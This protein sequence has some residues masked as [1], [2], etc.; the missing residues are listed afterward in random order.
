MTHSFQNRN[1]PDQSEMFPIIPSHMLRQ[2]APTASRSP[3]ASDPHLWSVWT[4]TILN[5][6][7]Y[8]RQ[9]PDVKMESPSVECGSSNSIGGGSESESEGDRAP[10]GCF[11]GTAIPKNC[12]SRALENFEMFAPIRKSTE[13]RHIRLRPNALGML[14]AEGDVAD[15]QW[16]KSLKLSDD[17]HSNNALLE[18]VNQKQLHVRIVKDLQPGEEILLWF[19]EE[20]LALMYIPFLTPANIRGES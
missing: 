11:A 15:H 16:I 4:D 20:L 3:F 2:P 17:T 9:R 1:D 10:T 8:V 19:S 7:S 5:G 14:H 18:T 13:K 12:H 6:N